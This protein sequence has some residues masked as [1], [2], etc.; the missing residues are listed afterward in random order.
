[1]PLRLAILLV[2]ALSAG[3]EPPRLGFAVGAR[4][5]TRQHAEA[6]FTYR[7]AGTEDD[8]TLLH[9]TVDADLE[10]KILKADGPSF[11]CDVT[12]RS[13]RIDFKDKKVTLELKDGKFTSFLEEGAPEI[14]GLTKPFLVTLA[15]SGKIEKVVP[16]DGASPMIARF[17]LDAPPSDTGSLTGWFGP[18]PLKIVAG[19][20][21]TTS[22]KAMLAREDFITLT[23]TCVWVPKDRAIQGRFRAGGRNWPKDAVEEGEGTLAFDDKGRISSSKVAWSAKTKAGEFIGSFKSRLDVTEP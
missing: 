7:V 10:W 14:P 15:E 19:Q 17:L 16:A 12:P 6:V 18:L 13:Y 2:V 20:E 11:H 21:W 9:F 1:M 3:Q 4:F 5:R 22:R 8:E 23:A